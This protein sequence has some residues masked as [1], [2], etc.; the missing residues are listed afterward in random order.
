MSTSK[1]KTSRTSSPF[2]V[3]ESPKVIRNLVSA[4][5]RPLVEV[6]ATRRMT[7]S[8]RGCMASRNIIFDKELG[9]EPLTITAIIYGNVV[10]VPDLRS[11]AWRPPKTCPKSRNWISPV[12]HQE[13]KLKLSARSPRHVLV[14]ASS[15]QIWRFTSICCI[16][17]TSGGMTWRTRKL[18]LAVVPPT[19]V[20]FGRHSITVPTSASCK[21]WGS[22]NHSTVA[23]AISATV[24]P[25]DYG[26]LASACSQIL[27]S[28]GHCLNEHRCSNT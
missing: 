6:A 9:L 13:N 28:S 16:F 8:K 3:Y 18:T 26:G 14:V 4:H 5:E 7:V 21:P 11:C 15:T 1:L 10:W 23:A 20:V 22:Q 2:V 27:N 12:R 19:T 25:R 17:L 24:N